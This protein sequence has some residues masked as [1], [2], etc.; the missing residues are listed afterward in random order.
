MPLSS[1]SWGDIG[2]LR[3]NL[4]EIQAAQKNRELEALYPLSETYIISRHTWMGRLIVYIYAIYRDSILPPLLALID[5]MSVIPLP[6]IMHKLVCR[7]LTSVR[8]TVENIA[9]NWTSA[10]PPTLSVPLKKGVTTLFENLTYQT[11]RAYQCHFIY[12][13]YCLKHA[14]W[15]KDQ[16]KNSYKDYLVRDLGE[17]HPLIEICLQDFEEADDISSLNDFD[18]CAMRHLVVAFSETAQLLHDVCDCCRAVKDH[19]LQDVVRWHKDWSNKTFMR[20]LADIQGC[21]EVES[22]IQ[23][24]IPFSTL[25]TMGRLDVRLKELDRRIVVEWVTA[26]ENLKQNQLKLSH[27]Q[28]V[29]RQ[30]VSIAAVSQIKAVTLNTLV[31][32]LSSMGCRRI[33]TEDPE[34]MRR[35]E[36][37]ECG[38]RIQCNGEEWILGKSLPLGVRNFLND[39][40]RVFLLKDKEG[41]ETDKVVKV[42]CNRFVL[43]IEQSQWQDE[44]THWGIRPL[45]PF[46]LDSEGYCAI[47]RRLDSEKNLADYRWKSVTGD[48]IDAERDMAAT[49]ANHAYFWVYCCHATPQVDI[50]HLICDKNGDLYSTIPMAKGEE[51]YNACEKLFIELSKGHLGVLNFLMKVSRLHLHPIAQFYRTIVKEVFMH[52]TVSLIA[53]PL[54]SAHDKACYQQ[55]AEKI[56]AKAKE[57]RERRLTTL[58]N[59]ARAVQFSPNDE[60]EDEFRKCMIEK[61]IRLYDSFPVASSLWHVLEEQLRNCFEKENYDPFIQWSMPEKYY[62]AEFQRICDYN[63]RSSALTRNV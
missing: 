20:S 4:S 16:I 8:E 35:R 34:H 15:P 23:Q 62:E 14:A 1:V 33:D 17:N 51:N 63:K 60:R 52:G 45:I 27:L 32:S 10:T 29:L 30:I 24:A 36:A 49:L 9:L 57:L 38:D 21:V 41:K 7:V 61:L 12:Q 40:Y 59:Q 50:K 55:R 2:R 19:P 28:C 25:L 5:G 3:G 18:V 42:G 37:M 56:I 54:P 26:L 48:L 44:K 58:I 31:V 39:R 43:L 6:H 47:Y 22:Q 46:S 53:H 11:Y 13:L